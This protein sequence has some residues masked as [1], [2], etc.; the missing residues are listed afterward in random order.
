MKYMNKN[1]PQIIMSSQLH[2]Y[3][4]TNAHTIHGVCIEDNEMRRNK[5]KIKEW[6]EGQRQ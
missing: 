4:K 2:F 5:T 1:E 3:N 6:L